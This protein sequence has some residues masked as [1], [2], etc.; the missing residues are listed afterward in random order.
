[1]AE[2]DSGALSA[3]NVWQNDVRN[4]AWNVEGPMR[5]SS[6]LQV[7]HNADCGSRFLR[8]QSATRHGHH[9]ESRRVPR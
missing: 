5:D 1:M 2:V 4:W 3:V 6:S 7:E 8:Q 9:A